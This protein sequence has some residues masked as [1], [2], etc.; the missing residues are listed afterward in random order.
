MHE[1]LEWLVRN[2]NVEPAHLA[3][4][5]RAVGTMAWEEFCKLDEEDIAERLRLSLGLYGPLVARPLCVAP[6]TMAFYH[7]DSSGQLDE[8]ELSD[9]RELV[10]DKTF[11]DVLALET[12]YELLKLLQTTL[13]EGSF[14]SPSATAD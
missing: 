12:S 11:C 7:L 9:L 6:V 14:L 5:R 13:T 10:G 4:M 2:S 1:I 3:G 8:D